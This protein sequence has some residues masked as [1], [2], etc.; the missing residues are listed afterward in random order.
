MRKFL[1]VLLCIL[2]IIAI[3][4]GAV[5]FFTANLAGTADDF[6]KATKSNDIE[7][8]YSLLSDD[9]KAATSRQA[10]IDFLSKSGLTAFKSASWGER[11][12]SGSRG[13]LTGTITTESGGAIPIKLSFTK[14]ESG[15]KIYSIEKPSAGITEEKPKQELQVAGVQQARSVPAVED[16]IKLVAATMHVFAVSVNEKSMAKF[17]AY[18]SNLMQS[19]YTVQKLDEAFASFYNLGN[20]LTVLD[21]YSPSFDEKALINA[22]GALVLKGHYPTQPSQ[23]YFEHEYIHDGKEW[24]VVGID[25]NIKKK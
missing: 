21:R 7:K 3:G 24:K 20:D 17:H 25:I 12:I 16:Q 8:A 18:C 1:N 19:Q 2:G 22:D 10:L 5:F 4:I 23:V 6:F 13:T 11:S 9:F 14:G 15:W